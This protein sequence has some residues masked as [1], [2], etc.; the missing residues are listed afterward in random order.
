MDGK[1][2]YYFENGKIQSEGT[3]KNGHMNGIFKYYDKAGEIIS[4]CEVKNG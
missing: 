3:Y 1:R 2:F 4:E